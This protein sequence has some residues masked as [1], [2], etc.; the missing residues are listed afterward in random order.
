M[1]ETTQSP[2][3][4]G[5]YE[6]LTRLATGGMAELFLARERGLAGLER[7]VVVKRIL[8]HL[9][10]QP[11]FVEMFLR[12]ARIVARLSHPNVV[13]I[14][15]LGQQQD[16]YHIAMEYIHGSTVRELLVLAQKQ[17]RS[18][19]PEVVVSIAEQACRGLHA[20]HEL[21]D[22]D[23]K[24]LGLVHRDISPHNL[25][26]ATDGH[27]KL[28]DF[29]VAKS[30]SASVE[31]TYS[32][33]LKG[34][35]AY[36]SP[37]QCRHESLD[38]RSDVFAMGIVLWEMLT[39]RRLF[40]RKTELQMMQAIIGGE[41][42]PPSKYCEDVP[43]R[44]E[45]V[46]FD[47]LEV[48][49]DDRF[50]SAEQMRLA[51]VDA[52]DEAGL[53][54]GEDRVAQFLSDVAGDRLAERQATV[55]SACE[56]ELTVSERRRLLH[57]TG[58]NSR[59]DA[60]AAGTGSESTRQADAEK[61]EQLVQEDR[62]RLMAGDSGGATTVE[63]PGASATHEGTHPG[64]ELV[65]EG[66]RLRRIG[67]MS[68][69]AVVTML[70]GAALVF[71]VA[72]DED[73]PEQPDTSAQ[74]DQP[75]EQTEQQDDEQEE[76]AE[77]QL[78]ILDEEIEV[79]GEPVQ[80]G[81]PPIVDVE[82]M[83]QEIEPLHRYL[84][85]EIGRPFPLSI[86]ESYGE[87]SRQLR[88][89][90]IDAALLTPNLYVLTTNLDEDIESLVMREF[91]GQLSTDGYLLVERGGEYQNLEDLE[92]RTFCFV[93]QGST[94]GYLLPRYYIRRQ[95][96]DPE[97]FIGDVQWSGD[98]FQAMRDLTDG[99]CQ[100]AA[101]YSGA[102]LSAEDYD[103]PTSGLRMMGTTGT[104][105]QDVI[106]VGEHTDDELR[107]KLAEV[108]EEFDPKEEFGLERLGANQRVTGFVYR[109]DSDF[110][111]LRRIVDEEG[112]ELDDL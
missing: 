108:L 12:E 69:V 64:D 75:T 14:Y 107:E 18:M 71:A 89:G 49:R 96:H 59:T 21:K 24:P 58:T 94:S 87:L 29:G 100:A 33:N 30:T 98:H 55:E 54:V 11:S 97:E 103:I 72:D 83:Q 40:K 50:E 25:M 85:Q 38:R 78:S 41:V 84:E 22:L 95:G 90:E 9:A 62:Q 37:E 80:L 45:Q 110:D 81:W 66:N 63:R 51:L 79:S 88:H 91:D 102:Y 57:M 68:A 46:V 43:Q 70:L 17:D 56:R 3:V 1:T 31:A 105:P 15:E 52:A 7:L 28:L 82:V 112:L 4:I 109:D 44:L 104:L 47:A 36:L 48:E 13:Q 39:M 8:P 60:P 111:T 74:A 5:R 53:D 76:P 34:K 6:L 23:G 10:D 20:A 73:E 2:E 42:P 27:V 86:P 93:H 32:G 19:P 65:E 106:A 16:S 67:M 61:L 26:C 101:V 92:G 35:F 77:A 99:K